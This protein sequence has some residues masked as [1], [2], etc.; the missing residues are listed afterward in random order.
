M[1]APVRCTVLV[2]PQRLAHESRP[3]LLVGKLLGIGFGFEIRRP[4]LLEA[5]ADE[6]GRREI[7]GVEVRPGMATLAVVGPGMANTPGVV[8]RVFAALSDRTRVVVM[9]GRLWNC[10][11][12][13][14]V[15]AIERLMQIATEVRAEAQ[16]K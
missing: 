4:E 8:P 15:E 6:I 11:G 14:V 2:H 13:A 10:G 12:P 9:P 7:D 3:A 1:L 5:F 16:T